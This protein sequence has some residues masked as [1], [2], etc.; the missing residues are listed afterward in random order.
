MNLSDQLLSAAL[1]RRLFPKNSSRLK[2]V[3]QLLQRGALR[4]YHVICNL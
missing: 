1:V 2:P 3:Q 4:D